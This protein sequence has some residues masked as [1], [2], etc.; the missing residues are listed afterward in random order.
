M[1]PALS[2]KSSSL[3]RSS[4]NNLSS[5]ETQKSITV[6]MKHQQQES[7]A[8]INGYKSQ[9]TLDELAKVKQQQQQSSELNRALQTQVD[10]S[11]P[12]IKINS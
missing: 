7:G 10:A 11:L 3:A 8:R 9:V 12:R 4:S 2:T 1:G 6:N 5:L